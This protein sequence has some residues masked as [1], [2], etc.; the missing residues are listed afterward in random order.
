MF[1]T[2]QYDPSVYEKVADAFTRNKKVTINQYNW[3]TI[4]CKT[5]RVIA[6]SIPCLSRNDFDREIWDLFADFAKKHTL[7]ILWGVDLKGSNPQRPM[8]RY[9]DGS[10]FGAIYSE[11]RACIDEQTVSRFASCLAHFSGL[12]IEFLITD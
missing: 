3:C 7:D 10:C 11:F 12:A 2:H 4:D 5:K 1:E 6:W 9:Y 8:I